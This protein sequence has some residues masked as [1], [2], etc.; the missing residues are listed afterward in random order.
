M[1]LYLEIGSLQILFPGTQVKIL[2]LGWVS[3]LIKRVLKRG[4]NSETDHMNMK[5]VM[6]ELRRENW[7]RSFPT[8]SEGTSPADIFIHDFQPPELWDN[9]FLLF[10]LLSIWYSVTDYQ[11]NLHNKLGWKKKNLSNSL[12]G[13]AQL[14]CLWKGCR[15]NSQSGHMPGYGLVPSRGHGRGN[16]TL[17]FLSLSFTLPSPLSENE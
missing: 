4:G 6:Y 8:P 12:V 13:V 17:M 2:S 10:K 5:T 14:A 1:W 7:N 15:F 11:E 9:Q 16:H 3:N